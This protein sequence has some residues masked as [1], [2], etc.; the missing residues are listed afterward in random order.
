V[1]SRRVFIISTSVALILVGALW[2][3][4]VGAEEEEL[5]RCEKVGLEEKASCWDALLTETLKERGLSSAFDLFIK[6]YRTEPDLPKACHGWG[7]ALGSAA[8]E[9]YLDGG[10]IEFRPEA[11]YCGYGF[12]HGFLERFMAEQGDVDTAR[13]FCA[14]IAKGDSWEIGAFR[15]CIHGVGHGSAAAFAE[16]TFL[17]KGDMQKGID[18]AAESCRKIVE[19]AEERREC[20]DGVFNEFVLDAFNEEYGF[21]RATYIDERDPL[22]FCETQTLDLAASCYFEYMGLFPHLFER[23]FHSA[24]S[25]VQYRIE[26]DA[27]AIVAIKKLAADFMQDRI[28]D[29][30]TS[31]IV[32]TCMALRDALITPCLRGVEVG[33]IAHGEPLKEWEKGFAHCSS[34]MLTSDD[35]RRVCYQ[36]ML[37]AFSDAYPKELFLKVCEMVPQQFRGELCP[38]V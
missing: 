6:L 31:D 17:L 34:D 16:N 2:W 7:H 22:R 23:D 35:E 12:Y 8:Y 20:F 29:G 26:N 11:S 18:L 38:R 19:K 32:A 28:V 9:L 1:Y 25:Y 10:D 15:N 14:D 4:S 13:A 21:S 37:W 24:A 33:F 5:R 27:H 36:S 30:D 3:G